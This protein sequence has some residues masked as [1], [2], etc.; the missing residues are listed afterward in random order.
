M[1]VYWIEYEFS[2]CRIN[3]KGVELISEAYNISLWVTKLLI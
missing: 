1:N 2:G 3:F